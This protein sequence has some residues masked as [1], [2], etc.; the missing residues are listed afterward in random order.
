MG[1]GSTRRKGNASACENR[2]MSARGS[3]SGWDSIRC[4]LAWTRGPPSWAQ[5]FQ[6]YSVPVASIS[7]TVTA[8]A[9]QK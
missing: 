4:V 6:A 8:S 9:H 7:G 2:P 1:R 5:Q 3:A